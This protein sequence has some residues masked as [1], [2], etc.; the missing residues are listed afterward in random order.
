MIAATTAGF[1]VLET[2][3]P[4]VYYLPPSAFA[5][6]VLT[7]ASGGSSCERKGSAQ[8]WSIRVGANSETGVVVR[9][10]FVDARS[11]DQIG[12]VDLSAETHHSHSPAPS[13]PRGSCGQIEHIPAL[14]TSPYRLSL[15]LISLGWPEREFAE[16][17]RKT[18]VTYVRTIQTE[19]IPENEWPY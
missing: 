8:Y 5:G 4:P 2:S 7:P 6:C 9:T 19:M 15:C 17:F 13:I 16:E 1:R 10:R 12:S 11:M 14:P 18:P 3:H